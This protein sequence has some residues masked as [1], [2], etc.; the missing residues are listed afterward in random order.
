MVGFPVNHVFKLR[1]AN[2][3]AC[4]IHITLL[5]HQI[6]PFWFFLLSPW[7]PYQDV[8]CATFF[9]LCFLNDLGRKKR[10]KGM[11]Y[12]MKIEWWERVGWRVELEL[13]WFSFQASDFS[14]EE[15]EK[16]NR[17][18]VKTERNWFVL[19]MYVCA[20]W[21]TIFHLPRS[22]QPPRRDPYFLHLI[23][24]TFFSPVVKFEGSLKYS[25]T[26]FNF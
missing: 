16:Q 10:L 20:V 6:S 7:E 25:F 23:F 1:R 22:H 24:L 5:H 14:H 17:Y 3:L 12:N 18:I 11:I 26:I 15:G 21:L 8:D 13:V 4:A 19:I 2:T 9:T